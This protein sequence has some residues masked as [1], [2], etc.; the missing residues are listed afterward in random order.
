MRSRQHSR[1][2]PLGITLVSLFTL[3][4]LR[5]EAQTTAFTYQGRLATGT[6]PANGIYDLRFALADALTFGN[7]VAGPVTNAAV[8]VNNGLFTVA[9]N[10]G[11]TP[12]T[13]ADRWLEIAVRTNGVGPFTG[14]APRQPLTPTPYALYAPL[15]GAATTVAANGV[16]P[17][18]LTDNAVTSGKIAAGQVVKS[19]NTLK[20][21]ITLAAGANLTITPAGNTLTLASPTWALGGNIGTTPGPQ[22]LGTTD[23][24]PL[25][26]KVNGG[27]ALRLEPDS[28]GTV[29]VIAG[30][31]NN[32]VAAGVTAATIGGGRANTNAAAGGTIGG[33]TQNSIFIGPS[34]ATIG[35]G[36]NNTAYGNYATIAGG[37][38]N[39]SQGTGATVGGGQNNIASQD[40]ATVGGGSANTASNDATTVGGGSGNVAGGNAAT[41]GG[42]SGN[43][44][45]GDSATVPGGSANVAAGR[46]SFA[47]GNRAKA[48]HLG[49][50]VWGD[51][52]AAD[53]VS[54]NTN[55]FMV[56]A[57][58]G[59]RLFTNPG[60]TS[61]ARL[62][63]GS[64][65][66]NTI[67]DRNVKKNFAPVDSRAVLERLATV[68]VQRWHYQWE[69]DTATPNI[70]PM[71]QD[72]KAAFYPGRDDKGITTLEV[73]G[74]ALAAIQGLNQ[75]L[76]EQLKTR[77]AEI[78]ELRRTLAEVQSALRA[79]AVQNAARP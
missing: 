47:A 49:A 44:A 68:P 69:P 66:W 15:A 40:G 25:E 54:S 48:N 76:E 56:R 53:V 46:N 64:S 55:Q 35:G 19:L 21:D 7:I 16:G 34:E 43:T 60:M 29:N 8:A 4:A 39:F 78:R 57:S 58:G 17:T 70:G 6:N 77:D 20:D 62:D 37:S 14:L 18:A 61:G 24:Q 3:A 74:V 9:L 41:I 28:A 72:F 63:A 22:F 23:N 1:L 11:A 30:A 79:L 45:S 13:G 50:F 38:Y 42:G 71:A 33:G 52:V 12:F 36:A 32:Q 59:V 51:A 5:S 31:A 73:D 10:F 75:K 65:S 27:R 67:S 2:V 26:V